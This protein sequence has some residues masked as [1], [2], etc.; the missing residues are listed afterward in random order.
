MDSSEYFGGGQSLNNAGIEPPEDLSLRM[1]GA[2]LGSAVG[3]AL[4]WPQEQ[5]SGMVGGN[6]ARNVPPKPEYRAWV[7]NGGT[8]FARY[9]DDVGV[10]EYSDDT[11]MILAVARSC[12]YE[13]QW[14]DFLTR[15]ELPAWSTYQRGGGRAMLSAA[16]SWLSGSAP[17]GEAKPSAARG[18]EGS[19]QSAYFQAG[20]N[21]VAMRVMP[22]VVHCI[23]QDSPHDLLERVLR[24]GIATHGHPRALLGGTI[25]ASV[26]RNTL[27][28][29]GTLGYGE[30]IEEL[31]DEKSWC[32]ANLLDTLPP[33]WIAAFSKHSGG[34]A[35]EAWEKTT[36]EVEALLALARNSIARG[37]LA[38][39]ERTLGELGCFDSR[40][41]GAGTVSAIAAA[42]LTSRSASRPITGLLRAAFLQN[43]D[44]DTLASMTAAT[45]G[46]LHGANWMG[47]LATQVQDGDYIAR[48]SDMLAGARPKVVRPQSQLFDGE[49]WRT[50]DPKLLEPVTQASV[51]R[52]GASL[53]K[54]DGHLRGRF[55]DGRQFVVLKREP[56][57]ASGSITVTR[58]CLELNDGQTLFIDQ[59]RRTSTKSAR[60]TGRTVLLPGKSADKLAGPGTPPTAHPTRLTLAVRDLPATAHF[61][62]NLLG[63]RVH[64]GRGDIRVGEWLFFRQAER[65]DALPTASAEKDCAI[66]LLVTDL[67]EVQR[68]LATSSYSSEI[69]GERI[70]L[71]DPDGRLVVVHGKA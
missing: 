32:D 18:A 3:D 33:D 62:R 36:S 54:N 49:D 70:E 8:R 23:R 31:L 20:A 40:T 53:S 21:G 30:L 59:S 17:W 65:A 11:Q 22:H 69:K 41:N 26:L 50:V 2:F 19:S 7:R 67:V 1:R 5:R 55:L 12:F 68:R 51:K 66:E 42:Y 4:G 71:R 61:Y 38:N 60:S 48:I 45:L 6:R 47:E 57:E 46:A 34:S 43:S 24:D 52:F 13:N 25:H 39:D 37:A 35:K 16:R 27:R 28:R 63:M 64:G 9:R 29:Q 56:L 15:V 14:W 10:G 44:T 58:W